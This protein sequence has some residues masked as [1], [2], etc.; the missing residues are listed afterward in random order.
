MI[1]IQKYLQ[2]YGNIVWMLYRPA[3]DGANGSFVGFNTANI[4]TYLFK[5]K[6]KITGQISDDDTKN[7]ERMVRSKYLRIFREIFKIFKYVI[8]CEINLDLNWS[9]NCV[10]ATNNT[11]QGTFFQ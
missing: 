9:E 5:I 1:I 6:E 8:N 10:K 3:I 4:A 2:L 7:T 11:D